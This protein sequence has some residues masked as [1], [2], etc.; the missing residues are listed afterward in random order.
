[1]AV[2]DIERGLAAQGKMPVD[3]TL[4]EMEALWQAAKLLEY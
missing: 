3:A 1:L 4:D 2:A